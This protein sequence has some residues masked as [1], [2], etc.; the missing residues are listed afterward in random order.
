MRTRNRRQSNS[1]DAGNSVHPVLQVA[2]ESLDVDLDRELARYRRSRPRPNGGIRR[3]WVGLS[4][5]SGRPEA[6]PVD[7]GGINV[8]PSQ[9]SSGQLSDADGLGKVSAIAPLDGPG[10]LVG[11]HTELGD[12]LTQ[13]PSIAQQPLPDPKTALENQ[14]LEKAALDQASALLQQTQNFASLGGGSLE[15]LPS[16]ESYAF[17]SVR[18]QR[19]AAKSQRKKSWWSGAGVAT[20]LMMTAGTAWTYY[21][22][23]PDSDRFLQVAQVFRAIAD[24]TGLEVLD[25]SAAIAEGESDGSEVARSRPVEESASVPGP[26]VANQEFGGLDLENLSLPEREQSSGDKEENIEVL[27]NATIP[28]VTQVPL[29]GAT[30]GAGD[31]PSAQDKDA[32][33]GDKKA[34]NKNQKA[35]EVTEIPADGTGYFYVVE[36]YKTNNPGD[37]EALL[38]QARQFVPDAYVRKLA[39]ELYIQFAAL[40][41]RGQAETLAKRLQGEGLTIRILHPKGA[42]AS[43]A[44]PEDTKSDDAKSDS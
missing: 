44:K 25:P 6:L 37:R 28:S 1:R 10:E 40:D 34:E 26:E 36:P 8:A 14:P 13:R 23:Y 17:P 21:A 27:A 12:A 30:A 11:D 35:P 32:E 38:A 19:R 5:K 4:P 3:F 24:A 7:E 31:Q 42:G 20:I 2:L 29:G 41:K 39:G 22:N 43:D 33:E 18:E 16:P 15:G 9:L